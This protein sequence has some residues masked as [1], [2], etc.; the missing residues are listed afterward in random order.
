MT[1]R[2]H[3]DE[4]RAYQANS[5]ENQDITSSPLVS[6]SNKKGIAS[7][8]TGLEPTRS[9]MFNYDARFIRHEDRNRSTHSQTKSAPS[10]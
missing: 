5:P 1:P 9:D 6:S 8:T 2:D 10:R 3:Q 7:C 4:K